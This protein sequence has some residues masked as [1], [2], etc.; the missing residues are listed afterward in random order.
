[1]EKLRMWESSVIGVYLNVES[2]LPGAEEP[3]NSDPVHG[4]LPAERTVPRSE[5]DK[6]LLYGLSHSRALYFSNYTEY[7]LKSKLYVLQIPGKNV[8]VPTKNAQ[9]REIWKINP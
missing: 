9:S 3:V 6:T 4:S 5:R 1:M 2:I 8:Y 7:F